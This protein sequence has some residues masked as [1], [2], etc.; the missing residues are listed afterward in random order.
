MIAVLNSYGEMKMNQ[1]ELK[2]LHKKIVDAGETGTTAKL[3]DI[4][5]LV[6]SK[7]VEVHPNG[8]DAEGNI[9]V[10]AKQ[11]ETPAVVLAKPAFQITSGIAPA[12]VQ[13]SG[14]TREEI[15]PFSKLAV[16]E[17]FLVPLPEKYATSDIFAEKFVSTIGS[18]NRRF[19]EETGETKTNRKGEVVK[20]LKATRKFVGRAVVVGQKYENGFV[21]PA[22]GVRVFR[23]A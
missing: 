5:P 2:K 10:R 6:D 22:N 23:I 12:P 11:S 21:E 15:Y 20:V 14:G 13:R 19:A 4:Q 17:S 18:A 1:K 3:A 9:F 7:L 16:N 8:P